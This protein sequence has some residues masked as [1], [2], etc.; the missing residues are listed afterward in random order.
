MLLRGWAELIGV[1]E[2]GHS[3]GRAYFNPVGGPYLALATKLPACTSQALGKLPSH[4]VLPAV[5]PSYHLRCRLSPLPAAP[6]LTSAAAP[7][8][9]GAG[10]QQGAPRPRAHHPLRA[11]LR[12]LRQ[13]QRGRHGAAVA[14]GGAAGGRD[15]GG[16]AR[17]HGVNELRLGR[18]WA[19]LGVVW[20]GGWGN[21]GAGGFGRG[22]CCG[23]DKVQ[24]A[25]ATCGGGDG[26]FGREG[27][28]WLYVLSVRGPVGRR[29]CLGAVQWGT[30]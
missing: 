28:L 5:G 22:P 7:P 21:T 25:R 16:G 8:P 1:V 24:A 13:R 3:T 19:G 2:G 9:A 10:V 29:H 6:S 4:C 17:C 18:G 15:S 27:R 23:G 14:A 12:R 11:L 20:D 26:T 30:A